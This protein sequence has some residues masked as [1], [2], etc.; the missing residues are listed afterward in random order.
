[1]MSSQ[2]EDNAK[3]G[4]FPAIF[5]PGSGRGELVARKRNLCEIWDEWDET[6]GAHKIGADVCFAFIRHTC[7]S[8]MIMV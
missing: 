8:D 7:Y 5:Y 1:M 4:P 2:K 6:G 3:C